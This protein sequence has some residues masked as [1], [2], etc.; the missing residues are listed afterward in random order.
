IAGTPVLGPS[1]P[2]PHA[3]PASMPPAVPGLRSGCIPTC[4]VTASP[5]TCLKRRR[6]AYHPDPVRPSRSER[7]RSLSP[8]FTS[9]LARYRQCPKCQTCAR[10][11]WIEARRSQLLPSPYVHVVFTLPRQLAALALQNKKVIYGLLL[12]ASAETLLEVARNPTHLGAEIG[13]FSVLPTWNQKLQ[14]H[15]HVHCVVPAGG[16]SRYHY[17][18]VRS[19]QLFCLL[20]PCV[21]LWFCAY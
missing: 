19:H 11:P 12:R 13:F 14:L 8:S 2:R 18:C 20:I 10:E 7:D 5:R 16:L 1:I 17:R 15:P 4:S 21:W 6:P 9:S 3:T